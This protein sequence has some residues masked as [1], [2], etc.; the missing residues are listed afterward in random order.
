MGTGVETDVNVLY[1]HIHRAIGQ[2][3]EA[4]HG[5][6]KPGEQE[7]SSINAALL[8]VELGVTVST[9]LDEGIAATAEW[10]RQRFTK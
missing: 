5:P 2:G 1:E 9:P 10:F 7:R 4:I 3:P 8:E 6:A